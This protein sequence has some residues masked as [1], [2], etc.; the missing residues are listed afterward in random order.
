MERAGHVCVDSTANAE[1]EVGRR[2]MW[3]DLV[4]Q[5]LVPGQPTVGQALEGGSENTAI[6]PGSGQVVEYVERD[7]SVAA[8]KSKDSTNRKEEGEEHEFKGV[9]VRDSA[10]EG[11]ERPC[12]YDA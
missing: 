10:V 2:V 6:G 9:I 5:G 7:V 4:R 12:A 11:E 8:V 1:R 3:D